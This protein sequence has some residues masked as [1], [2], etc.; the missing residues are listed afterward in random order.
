MRCV[1]A[2]FNQPLVGR[3]D[4]QTAAWLLRGHSEAGIELLR[5]QRVWQFG[6]PESGGA[7]TETSRQLPPWQW[8]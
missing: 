7:D 6:T 5:R 2:T 3:A 1:R 4:I 8:R